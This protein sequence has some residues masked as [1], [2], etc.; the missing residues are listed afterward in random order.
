MSV[1]LGPYRPRSPGAR[2]A[3][4]AASGDATIALIHVFGAQ[5]LARAGVVGI[6]CSATASNQY[7]IISVIVFF[8]A[9]FVALRLTPTPRA[10]GTAGNVPPR[11]I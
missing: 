2:P 1:F 11:V 8:V 5:V 3:A 7:A 6:V 9:G 10:I 4:R